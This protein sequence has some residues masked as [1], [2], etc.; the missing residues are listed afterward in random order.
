MATPETF[1]A[2]LAANAVPTQRFDFSHRTRNLCENV[3]QF[4]YKCAHEP[5]LAGHRIQEHVHKTVPSL[6]ACKSTTAATTQK[7]NGVMFDLTY[8]TEFLNKLDES[9][10]NS[11]ET[12]EIISELA[13]KISAA[14]SRATQSSNR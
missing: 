8:T 5:S 3:N 9:I 13:S 4:L 6:E 7:I 14:S 10:Q 12:R 11:T 1:R 2:L